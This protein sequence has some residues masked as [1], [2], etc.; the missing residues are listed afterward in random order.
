MGDTENTGFDEE[1]TRISAA[2]TEL[3]A[4]RTTLER[5]DGG[6]AQDSRVQ[7]ITGALERTDSA[8]VGFNEGIIFQT[9]SRV[10]VLDK[11]RVSVRF[12]DGTELEQAV[13]HR[14]RRNTA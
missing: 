13:E 10:T 4:R 1:L 2:I 14:Q 11:E 9:V 3:L 6:A 8:I 5:E 7:V 12:K